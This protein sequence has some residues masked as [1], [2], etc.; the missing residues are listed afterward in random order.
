MQWGEVVCKA[1]VDDIATVPTVTCALPVGPPDPRNGMRRQGGPSIAC[2]ITACWFV[3]L[4]LCD[5]CFYLGA[6]FTIQSRWQPLKHLAR[7]RTC[8]YASKGKPLGQH[9]SCLPLQRESTPLRKEQSPQGLSQCSSVWPD[10]WGAAALWLHLRA[11]RVPKKLSWLHRV[12]KN[13]DP[14]RRGGW[15]VGYSSRCHK[16]FLLALL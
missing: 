8:V 3:F 12:N 5:L 9:K 10:N 14:A 7:A 15:P 13:I 1:D 4:H 11:F 6:A 16:L 2:N